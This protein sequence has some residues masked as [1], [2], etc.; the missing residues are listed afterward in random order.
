MVVPN[1][2]RGYIHLGEIFDVPLSQ[3]IRCLMPSLVTSFVYCLVFIHR[4]FLL[5]AILTKRLRTFLLLSDIVLVILRPRP[6]F[7]APSK[8]KSGEQTHSDHSLF[9]ALFHM[10]NSVLGSGKE[11]PMCLVC[12]FNITGRH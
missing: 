11:P 2:G 3:K 1:A 6:C 5:R 7:Y 10:K 12:I 4:S 9:W 8:I